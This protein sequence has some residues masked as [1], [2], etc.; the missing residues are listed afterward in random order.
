MFALKQIVADKLYALKTPDGS[1]VF[2]RCFENWQDVLYL[3]DFFRQHAYALA[4]YKVD[5][6]TAIRQVLSES[7]QF[8]SEILEII[9]TANHASPLDETIFIPLHNGEDFDLPIIETKAY[10]TISRK[11]YLRLYAIRLSDG[12]YIVVGGLIKTTRSLQGSAEGRKI[13]QTLKNIAS[14]LR[15]SNFEDAFDIGVLIV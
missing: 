6:K 8:F 7:K 14:F 15:K 2:H 10:G 3:H 11:C 5:R 4:F 9:N 13:L 1:D 12:C